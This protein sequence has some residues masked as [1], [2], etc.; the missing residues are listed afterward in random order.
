VVGFAAK[1]AKGRALGA[2]AGHCEE[3]CFVHS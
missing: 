3:C 1:L 2:G